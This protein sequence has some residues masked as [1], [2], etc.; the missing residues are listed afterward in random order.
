M[1]CI[2]VIDLDKLWIISL[3]FSCIF[4]AGYVY[5]AA[6]TIFLLYNKVHKVIKLGLVNT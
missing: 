2:L 5:D 3:K 4:A 1:S 6:P